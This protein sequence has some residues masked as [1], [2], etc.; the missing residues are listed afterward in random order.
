M[1]GSNM[2][3]SHRIDS[4]NVDTGLLPI[5]WYLLSLRLGADPGALL[6]RYGVTHVIFPPP[7]TERGRRVAARATAGGRDLGPEPRTGFRI[8]EVPARPWA[9]FPR[10]VV[11]AESAGAAL[12]IV[13][14]LQP[15]VDNVAVVE[16][17]SAL[18]AAPGRILSV[19]RSMEWLEVTAEAD[20]AATLVVNDA[21]WPGWRAFID[22]REVPI[23]P[24]DGVVRAVPWPAGLHTL[25]MRYEPSEPKVGAGLS[26]AGAG[27]MLGAIALSR[28][29]ARRRDEARA[30]AA[31][32]HDA[33]RGSTAA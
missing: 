14:R 29:R 13:E 15:D 19:A 23:F 4:L 26:A 17:P 31:A 9:T 33:R 8:W 21:Y 7:K 16:A 22:G 27:A 11:L 12:D 2:N 6:R 5:R 25:V 20:A 10:E 3:A 18:P 30:A 28:H 32:G 24:A 1:L